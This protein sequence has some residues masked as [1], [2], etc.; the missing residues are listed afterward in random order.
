M[1][2]RL[3]RNIHHISLYRFCIFIDNQLFSLVAMAKDLNRKKYSP[4]MFSLVS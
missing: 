2:L 4:T 1:K 3:Y